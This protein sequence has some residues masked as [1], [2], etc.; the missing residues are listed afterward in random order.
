MT[1]K[2]ADIVTRK[3]RLESERQPLLPLYQRLGDFFQPD[4]ADFTRI[5]GLGQDR[6]QELFTGTP[7]HAAEIAAAGLLGWVA[8]PETKWGSVTTV[9]PITDRDGIKW[10][11][12]FSELSLNIINQTES[13][14]YD[15]FYSAIIDMLVFAPGGILVQPNTKTIVEYS[16]S[17]PKELLLA[18]NA[19]GEIDTVYRPYTNTVRQLMQLKDEKEKAGIIFTLSAS[20]LKKAE[21]DAG[22]DEEIACIH[23]MEPNPERKG[24]LGQEGMEFRGIYVEE[25][26]KSEIYREG[27]E[28]FPLPIERWKKG[29]K[30]PYGRSPGMKALGIAQMLNANRAMITAAGEMA[31]SPP[32]QMF[33]EG[34]YSVDVSANALNVLKSQESDIR[35]IDVLG[36]FNP[37]FELDKQLTQELRECFYIDIFQTQDRTERTATE[38]QYRH[39]AIMRAEAPSIY[40]IQRLAGLVFL[41][42][43]MIAF[44]AGEMRPLPDSLRK[45][46]V[47]MVFGSPISRV[48]HG[49]DARVISELIADTQAAMAVD[50]QAGMEIDV[51]AGLREL[52]KLKGAPI[53]MLRSDED[54]AAI[55]QAQAQAQ[56]MQQELAAAQAGAKAAKDANAAGIL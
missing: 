10:L 52:H 33:N 37:S 54:K 48:M 3:K 49:E 24:E 4:K 15:H 30:D 18:E 53:S 7:E 20:V 19:A 56:G 39:D 46:Q 47:K 40:R 17:R 43:G 34:V 2:I 55:K 21:T 25:A 1:Q 28:E 36:D 8:N 51:A 44:R 50:P 14:F 23:A 29:G 11:E 45:Q 32:L 12:E 41:R 27:Y 42:T 38:A 26:T 35:K 13:K 5:Y 16:A 6:R 9:K 31:L 22:M